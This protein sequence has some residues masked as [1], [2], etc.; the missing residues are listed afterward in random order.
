MTAWSKYAGDSGY[1]P[2]PRHLIEKTARPFLPHPRRRSRPL[3]KYL[4][5]NCN[6]V[7]AVLLWHCT[8]ERS[9][10]DIP[11]NI[12]ATSEDNE[13]DQN[14]PLQADPCPA[15]LDLYPAT[16]DCASCTIACT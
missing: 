15:P 9:L 16:P 7:A 13:S 11:P 3:G 14:F 8:C 12:C 4:G 5:L 6:G 10:E 2:C 1:S